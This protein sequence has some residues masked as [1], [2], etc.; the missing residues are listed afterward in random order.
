MMNIAR[1]KIFLMC[2]FLPFL[3]P[4]IMQVLIFIA[5]DKAGLLIPITIILGGGIGVILFPYIFFLIFMFM[6]SKRSTEKRMLK[7]ALCSPVIFAFVL[8]LLTVIYQLFSRLFYGDTPLNA[9][10]DYMQVIFGIPL[11]IIAIGYFYVVLS[12][13]LYHGIN[14]FNKNKSWI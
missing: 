5:N 2:L 14:Y 12:L 1:R 13:L 7:V 11:F 10:S 4:L 9:V 8:S 6:L 3:V